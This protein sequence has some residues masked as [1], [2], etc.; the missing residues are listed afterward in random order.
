MDGQEYKQAHR[1]E[2]ISGGAGSLSENVGQIG[3]LTKKIV[4]WK[5]FTMP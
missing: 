4:Q 2:K 1:N 3:S 5:S